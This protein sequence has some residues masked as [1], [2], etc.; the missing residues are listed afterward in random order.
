MDH[1]PC[2]QQIRGSDFSAA[3]P[4]ASERAAFVEK[5]R[6]RGTV[7]RAIDATTPE[8]R[9]IRGVDDRVNA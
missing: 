4:A 1:M 7:D 5:P 2:R 9:R 8:Q 6:P 3:G